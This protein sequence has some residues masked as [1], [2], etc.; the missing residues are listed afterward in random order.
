M[1]DKASSFKDDGIVSIL[2]VDVAVVKSDTAI[3][4]HLRHELKAACRPLETV[5]SKFKDWHPGSD[6]KVLDLVHPSLF[7][8]VY[9]RSKVITS[10]RIGMGDCISFMDQGEITVHPE[11][12]EPKPYGN[13]SDKPE[14]WSRHFQWLPCLVRFQDGGTVKISS[15]I[16]NLH[17]SKFPD[18]YRVIEECIAKAIPLWDRTLSS[19][20]EFKEPRIT[21]EC[22]EY[23]WPL[24]EQMPDDFMPEQAAIIE[25]EWDR[26]DKRH[27]IWKQSRILVHPEPGTYTSLK[28]S[29]A[30]QFDLKKRF[31]HSGLQV[32]VKLANIELTPQKPRYEGGS[33]HIEG[34]MNERI[35]ASAL[36]YYDSENITES[37]LGF[38]QSINAEILEEKA[39]DQVRSMLMILRF[40]HAF[41]LESLTGAFLVG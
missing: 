25:D 2:D 29:E 37:F 3:P 15:Y 17:P 11:Q 41:F 28:F 9:G 39:Y 34:Q 14:G 8:L 16:N 19:I 36:Y 20:R 31:E 10:Q 38:R 23:H 21:M 40:A 32:I 12:L 4:S 5:P 18:L 7:P 30:E 24:G 27:E 1:Q 22:T 35:C 26:E 6:E 13:L 33:W